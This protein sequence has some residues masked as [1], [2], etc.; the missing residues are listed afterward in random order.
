MPFSFGSFGDI[1]S[2]ASLTREVIKA[3]NESRGS[4]AEYR[5]L[6]AELRSLSSSLDALHRH[7]SV[8][9][10]IRLEYSAENGIKF[11][12]SRCQFLITD[13]YQRM[14]GYQNSLQRGGSGSRMR[15]SWRK[16]GWSIFKREEVIDLKRKL[17]DQKN[18]IVLMLSMSDGAALDRIEQLSQ[19]QQSTISQLPTMLGQQG[20]EGFARVLEEYAWTNTEQR[21]L[22][23][24]LSSGLRGELIRQHEETLNS[25]RATQ[26]EQVPISVQGYLDEFSKSMAGEVRMLLSEVDGLQDRKHTLQQEILQIQ[27]MRDEALNGGWGPTEPESSINNSGTQATSPLT[28]SFSSPDSAQQAPQL[29]TAW[30]Q[31]PLYAP[32]PPPPAEPEPESPCRPSWR[33]VTGRTSRRRKRNNVPELSIAMPDPTSWGSW[34]RK[35]SCLVICLPI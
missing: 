28:T 35:V 20:E 32:S 7:L 10:P 22:I 3:L 8:R 11:A 2:L 4:S 13:F 21:G 23:Y 12:L 29:V 1:V 33:T 14:R 6:I 25:L 19:Q 15:D 24:A 9:G 17:A 34:L 5:N 27:R 30:Q 16:I 18:T 31:Q 26:Q